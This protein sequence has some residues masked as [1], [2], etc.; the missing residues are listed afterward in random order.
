MSH[1]SPFQAG[2]LPRA[3][4][5]LALACTVA[6][7]CAEHAP[8]ASPPDLRP[9]TQLGRR[10]GD[11]PSTFGLVADVGA[12]RRERVYVLDVAEKRLAV[13][14]SDGGFTQSLGREG[15]GPGEFQVPVALAVDSRE[16]MYVLDLARKALVVF[17]V[18]GGKI[19]RTQDLPLHLDAEDLC[20]IGDRLYALGARDGRLIHEISGGTGTV[21]RSIAADPDAGDATMAGV[22]AAGYLAC[23][24]GETI[25]FLPS[26]RP[27]VLRFSAATGERLGRLTIPDYHAVEITAQADGRVLFRA[28][29]G[30]ETDNAS[31][32][33]PLPDGRQLIQVG[34]VV[35]GGLIPQFGPV[36]TLVVDWETGS[37]VPLPRTHPRVVSGRGNLVFTAETDPYPTVRVLEVAQD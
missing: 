8:G 35:A 14:S 7:A 31:S 12:D 30:K 28:P 20:T 4:V 5:S 17:D 33:T 13:F 26:G 2:R 1:P 9:L 29:D 34:N 24:P 32:I 22:R 36:R 37:V 21:I 15:S 27:E 10:E 11:G 23:G 19:R 18:S 3:L 16:R 6:A 25:T